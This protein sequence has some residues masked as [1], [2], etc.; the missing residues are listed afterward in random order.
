[1]AAPLEE[2]V[3][4]RDPDPED[5]AE[6][7]RHR[8]GER[9]V[10]PPDPFGEDDHVL[11]VG[12]EDDAASLERAEV[13]GGRETRGY[14]PPGDRHVGDL[15]DPVQEGAP[16]V[17]HAVLLDVDVRRDGGSLVHGELHAVGAPR[18]AQVAHLREV[19]GVALVDHPE[20]ARPV[21]V[22]DRAWVAEVEPRQ[23][24]RDVGDD[25]PRLGGARVEE[26]HPDHV[27][28]RVPRGQ[29][30]QDR[31]RPVEVERHRARWRIDV[32][33]RA[34]G[35]AEKEDRHAVEL[36]GGRV[37]G[38]DD[39]EPR[40]RRLHVAGGDER[41]LFESAADS[42]RAIN[43]D[44]HAC[45]S[46]T[47]VD[48]ASSGSSLATSGTARSSRVSSSTR[49]PTFGQAISFPYS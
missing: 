27:V 25:D 48:S 20:D 8:P 5:P 42:R 9:D 15:E 40:H 24:F 34:L 6:R 38:R 35:D 36:R 44:D 33:P 28:L 31:V 26:A 37:E 16:R 19:V 47:S 32:A 4:E 3:G 39:L 23:I 11:V 12:K 29:R 1:M 41:I 22:A 17:L 18:D 7:L 21:A 2:I 45:A 14:P 30:P 46:G 43:A 13:L 49:R 10:L